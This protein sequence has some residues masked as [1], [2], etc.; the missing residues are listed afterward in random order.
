MKYILY[1]LILLP[2]STFSQDK[3]SGVVMEANEKNEHIPLFGANVY[4]LDTAVGTTTDLDGN[5]TIPYSTAYKKL[6]ISYVGYKTDT[7]N[8]TEP[9]AI[10]HLLEAT[11]DLDEVTLTSRKQATAKSYLRA[12]KDRKSVV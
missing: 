6:V 10:H 9:K 5:F 3:I 11:S 2:I 7:L 4:W 1:I 12:E 8:I